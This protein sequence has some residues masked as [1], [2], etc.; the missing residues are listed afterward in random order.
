MDNSTNICADT[1]IS[2]GNDAYTSISIGTDTNT[3]IATGTSIST[4]TSISIFTDTNFW[5]CIDSIDASICLDAS[6]R[7]QYWY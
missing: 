6:I 7:Y 3:R 4:N 2:V 5:Y 1:S